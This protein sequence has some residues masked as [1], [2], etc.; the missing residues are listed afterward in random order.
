M[1]TPAQRILFLR[2]LALRNARIGWDPHREAIE[3][4]YRRGVRHVVTSADQINR[5]A[6]LY[7]RQ[8]SPELVPVPVMGV[9]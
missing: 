5:L 7:R 2:V 3:F 4:I 1:S 8:I 6:R 9:L